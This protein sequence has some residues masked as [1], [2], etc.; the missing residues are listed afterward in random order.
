MNHERTIYRPDR[1]HE[2]IGLKNASESEDTALQRPDGDSREKERAEATGSSETA[3][4]RKIE[5][6]LPPAVYRSG[7]TV[8]VG[9]P[10]DGTVDRFLQELYRRTPPVDGVIVLT[11]EQSATDVLTTYTDGFV[12]ND[13]GR[14]EIIDTRSAGQYIADV[15]RRNPIHYTAADGD[16]ERT[17]M[18]LTELVEALSTTPAQRLH[19]IVDSYGTLSESLSSSELSKLLNAFRS[20]IDGYRIYVTD[21]GD[22]DES[23][24]GIASGALWIEDDV[25]SATGVESRY[26]RL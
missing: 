10:T 8:T 25:D 26:R 1:A 2:S 9:G 18:S 12:E 20:Q 6:L 24:I 22:P 15:Y 17:V 14:I 11:T 4:R 5:E 16:I 3:D 7:G 13:E 21:D 19:L 23:L